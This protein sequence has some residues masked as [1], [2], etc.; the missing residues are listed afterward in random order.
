MTVE[1]ISIFEKPEGELDNRPIWITTKM[2]IEQ[3]S[4]SRTKLGN[5]M[6]EDETF[7]KPIYL[8]WN[9]YRW[10]R[11]EIENWINYKEEIRSE[12]C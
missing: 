11:E 2:L 9:C 8:G 4:I 3:L 5:L 1:K 10:K 12:V 6:E 7:P